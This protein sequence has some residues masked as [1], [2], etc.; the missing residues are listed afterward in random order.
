MRRESNETPAAPRPIQEAKRT[1]IREVMSHDVVTVRGDATLE[2]LADLLL[3]RG[4]SRVP[5]VDEAG[6]P[7]GVIGKTDLVAEHHVRGD[8]A[9]V[10]QRGGRSPGEHVHEVDA[11]V[12][13]VMTPLTVSLP[14]TASVAEAS[15]IMVT[16]NLH[17][18][19]IVS[20]G[21]VVGMLS[22]TD[23]VAWV[24]GIRSEHAVS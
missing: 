3:V 16:R 24:A 6:R 22:S 7:I 11:L 13:D 5:V 12:R 23:V 2:Q 18:L 8:T 10:D 20:D 21:R 15:Q 19:P 17:A 14:P 9:E 4:L 1:P